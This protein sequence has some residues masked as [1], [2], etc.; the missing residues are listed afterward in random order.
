MAA[1]APGAVAQEPS[2]LRTGSRV[3]LVVGNSAYQTAPLRN[4]VADAGAVADALTR[5]GFRV[6]LRTNL[7]LSQMLDAL[8][9]FARDTR[10]D[11]VRL[12]FYAGH[13]LQSRGENYLLP[14]DAQIEAPEDVPLMAADVQQLVDHLQ[15]SSKGVNIV[16]LDACRTYPLP[17][18]FRTG[19]RGGRPLPPAGGLAEV[20]APRGTVIAFST[21]PGSVAHDGPAQHS[22]YVKYVLANIELPGLS[23]EELFKRVRAGVTRETQQAQMPWESSSL[24]GDFCFRPGPRGECPAPGAAPSGTQASGR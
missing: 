10:N 5:L 14:V 19:T 15:R 6:S 16:I 12:F 21:A 2:L 1:A 7:D 20:Q 18:K 4:P 24:V 9:R 13:A 17:P 23:L 8:T 3:A 11:D 22:V